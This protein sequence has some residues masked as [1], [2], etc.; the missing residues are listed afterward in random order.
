MQIFLRNWFAKFLS[1]LKK[2]EKLKIISP[3]ITEQ[4]IRKI[5]TQFEFKNFELITRFKLEDFAMKISSL[6]A[7]KFS[8]ENGAKVFGIKDLH[9]KVYLFDDRKAI[10]TS[11]NLT[12][13]GLNNNYECGI[14]IDDSKIIRDL[15]N[16]FDELKIISGNPLTLEQCEEWQQKLPIIKPHNTEIPSLPDYGATKVH[17]DKGKNYYIKFFGTSKRRYPFSLTIKE[18]IANAHCHYACGFSINKKPRQVN[19]GDII[20]MACMTHSPNNYAIFGKAEAIKF[21]EDR[22][23]ATEAEIEQIAW[24]KDF[25]IYL[26]VKNPIFIN[27]TLGDCVLLYDLINK[28]NYESFQ[29]TKRRYDE[30][31]R[32]I[33]PYRSLSQKPYIR[34]TT[35]AAE[36]VETR[37]Q[38]GLNHLGQVDE[39]FIKN[40][41]QSEWSF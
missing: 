37:F 15:H 27:G 10:V 21:V 13:G 1:E 29:S 25:P 26:R 18:E 39:E 9:S 35:K 28:M 8:V 34:L 3:F 22:D 31:E 7:L 6:E 16:Y 14:C 23:K 33:N 4:I 30:G 40:L 11:A 5:N 12:Y 38:E 24:K 36:W 2:T 17:I 32:N 20:Y 41:P 19:D